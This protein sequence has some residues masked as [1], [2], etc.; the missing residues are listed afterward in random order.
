MSGTWPTTA[1]QLCRRPRSDG[2]QQRC[3]PCVRS[4]GGIFWKTARTVSSQGREFY[5][6]PAPANVELTNFCPTHELAW[7]ILTLGIDL[8][9]AAR[10]KP[11]YVWLKSYSAPHVFILSWVPP[12]ILCIRIHVCTLHT[13][14]TC[15]HMYVCMYT[16]YEYTYHIYY[17]HTWYIIN[18]HMVEL[19]SR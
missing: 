14:I 2:R 13:Y 11:N 1:N 4:R 15:M 3:R 7:S 5:T 10:N 18:L 12:Y 8:N 6:T 19:N 16:W 9:T 17:I